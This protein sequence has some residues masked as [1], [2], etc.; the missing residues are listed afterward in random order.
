M[1]KRATNVEHTMNIMS[2]TFLN[3][4]LEIFKRIF[5]TKN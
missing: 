2:D 3:N 1:L 5:G 4:F